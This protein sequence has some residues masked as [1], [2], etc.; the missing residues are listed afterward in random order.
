M[1]TL[2]L[3][4]GVKRWRVRWSVALAVLGVHVLAFSSVVP[5]LFS[6]SGLILMFAGLYVFGTLGINLCYHRLL[7]HRSFTC[8]SWAEK[9]LTVIGLCNFQGSSLRWVA[10][11]R[12]H[13][14]HSDDQPD[15][16]SPLV[17]FLWSHTGWLLIRNNSLDT[18]ALLNKYGRDLAQN[19]FHMQM[20]RRQRWLWVWLAHV[21][22]IYAAGM[23]VGWLATGRP[24]GGVQLGLSWLVWA[25]LMRTVLVWHITWSINSVTHLW[26]YRNFETPD[27]S[28]NNWLLGYIGMG[29][30]WHNNH[31]ADQRS[32]AHGMRWW[33]LDITYLTILIMQAIR[34]ASNVMRP[35]RETSPLNRGAN[36]PKTT[37]EVVAGS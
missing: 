32:A 29:E 2:Q 14:Q 35:S 36:P 19:R 21:V 1:K 17:D 8:P 26:G 28:R 20:E 5:W 22:F 34:L 25:F 18:V 12:M 10:S 33:E 16:H 9:I 13:H 23:T 30:G 15:P 24:M 27:N 37:G 6:W 3:P 11:H 4:E 31:H 7:T